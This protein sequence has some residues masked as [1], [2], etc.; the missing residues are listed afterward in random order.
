MNGRLDIHP[1]FSELIQATAAQIASLVTGAVG[2]RGRAT[3]A[4][5]GGSTPRSVYALLGSEPFRS[6]ILWKNVHVFW[7]DE[8]CV[9]PESSESNYR[10]ANEALL[11][12]IAIPQQ[13]VHRIKAEQ[14]PST[15]AKEYEAEIRR[16]F[17]LVDAALPR[18][19]IVLLGLGDDGHTASLFPGTSVLNEQ[20]KLVVDTYVEK[21]KAYRI[22]LTLPVINN[23]S[24]IL[25]L[26]S[27]K[28]K[29]TILRDVLKGDNLL[30]PAQHVRP[31]AGELLWL[32]DQDAASELETVHHS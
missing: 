12:H 14:S 2:A 30:L 1:T 10:M 13:N 31:S 32:V 4:L 24:H 27:G 8:R 18:F 20:R 9:S 16:V 25:F 29:A 28:G 22:T 5:S 15:A 21:L 11:M 7:G 26:V 17:D 3:I 6:R 23:A 19:D